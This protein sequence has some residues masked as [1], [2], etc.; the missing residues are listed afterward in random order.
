MARD[1]LINGATMTYVQGGTHNVQIDSAAELG[2]SAD[3]IR[4]I[5][6]FPHQDIPCND[7]GPGT[8]PDVLSKLA[9]VTISMILVHY[10]QLVLEELMQNS[11]GWTVPNP[12]AMKM[13]P[14]GTPLGGGLPM[15]YSGNALFSVSLVP[16]RNNGQDPENQEYRF[17]SCYLEDQPV[18]IPLGTN[19]SMVDVRFRAIPYAPLWASGNFPNSGTVINLNGVPHTSQEICCSGNPIWDYTADRPLSGAIE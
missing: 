11:L 10:D 14:Y 7:F 18:V 17:K 5:P 15:Y 4:I 16:C 2:L 13:G 1:W 19:Y 8:P 9:D 12:L 3:Q 6:R